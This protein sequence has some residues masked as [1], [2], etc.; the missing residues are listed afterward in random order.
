MKSSLRSKRLF[1]RASGKEEYEHN[2]FGSFTKSLP[3]NKSDIS[4]KDPVSQLQAGFS[5]TQYGQWHLCQCVVLL[6]SN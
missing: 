6:T 4:Y 1:K 5:F 2:R 3:V